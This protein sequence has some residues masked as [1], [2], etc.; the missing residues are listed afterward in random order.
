MKLSDNG[1]LLYCIETAL[2]VESKETSVVNDFFLLYVKDSSAILQ[3][4]DH[5]F[6]YTSKAQVAKEFFFCGTIIVIINGCH[7]T[8]ADWS[9]RTTLKKFDLATMPTSN[10]P[11]VDNFKHPSHHIFSTSTGI[12]FIASNTVLTSNI[13]R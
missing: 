7:C 1:L 6:N 11:Y 3:E 13:I 4:G 9:T 5:V 10:N 12:F 2:P 8:V